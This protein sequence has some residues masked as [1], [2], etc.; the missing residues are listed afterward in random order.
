MSE[1]KQNK[2]SLK[3]LWI[4]I[5][6]IIV[7]AVGVWCGIAASWGKDLKDKWGEITGS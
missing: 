1:V 6:L 2:K 3:W 5:A 4:T 7:V